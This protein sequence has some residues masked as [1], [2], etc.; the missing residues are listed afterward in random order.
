MTTLDCNQDSLGVFLYLR[1][2]GLLFFRAQRGISIGRDMSH[3]DV[4]KH[5]RCDFDHFESGKRLLC[6]KRPF[7]LSHEL[8]AGTNDGSID[9]RDEILLMKDG[10][11][12]L[13]SF[14]NTAHMRPP[15][16][17]TR[18]ELPNL[19]NPPIVVHLFLWVRCQF[20]SWTICGSTFK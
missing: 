18:V 10:L 14:A 12:G 5:R 8:S 17:T 7:L 3:R 6:G 19:L 13:K 2:Y 9:S 11:Q 15:P 16:K 4:S 1:F 20:F